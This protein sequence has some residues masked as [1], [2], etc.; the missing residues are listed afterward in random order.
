MMSL[1]KWIRWGKL[2][3]WQLFILSNFKVLLAALFFL[4]IGLVIGWGKS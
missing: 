4:T 2:T 1:L 3:K